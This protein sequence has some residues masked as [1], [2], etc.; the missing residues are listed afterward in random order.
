V[1]TLSRPR[2]R[3]GP[4]PSGRI[5][6]ALVFLAALA[7]LAVARAHS[8]SGDRLTSKR[9][10]AAA[11]A[12]P[13][14]GAFLK[15]TGY[16]RYR[17]TPL[18]DRLVRVSFFDGSRIVLEA[19]VAPDG[20]VPH[21]LFYRPGYIRSG[22]KTAQRPWVLVL[23]CAVFALA[24]A[25]VPLRSLRNLDVLALVSFTVPAA[26]LNARL[27]EASVYTSYP[28]LA[29][30]AGRCL[31][32][33]LRPGGAESG[34]RPG[35]LYERVTRSWSERARGRML[36]IG[37]ISASVGLL[38]VSIPG[39]LVGDVAYA[40]MAGATDL[41]HG[42]LP[43]GHLPTG[44]LVHG[45]TYPLL[46]YV[47]Y[48]PAAIFAPVKDGFDNMDGALYVATGFALAAAAALYVAG[49]RSGGGSTGPRLALA[50]LCFPPVVIAA[51][52]GSND[53]AAASCVAFAAALITYP[54]G[55]AFAMTLASWIKIGPFLILPAW[56]LR[57]RG[58]GLAR[59]LAAV[60]AVTAAVAT[61]VIALGGTGG[62]E[63]MLNAVSFQAGR[64]SLLSIWTLTG[65]QTLQLGFQAA[66]VTVA[67]LGAI[68]ARRDHLFA[69][70]P[71]R[72]AALAAAVLLGA[73]I[74]ANYWTYAYLPWVF[75]LIALA[76][77]SDARRR[78]TVRARP[79]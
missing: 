79:A 74:G 37:L 60:A 71:R 46:A 13:E 14:A 56:V 78:R 44:D 61:W 45:D 22:S 15:E 2:A 7:L 38:L 26:L 77:L 54:A 33:A 67:V 8:S 72:V 42:V 24:T 69:R 16:T 53:L 51:S 18:D 76:L 39:G 75:P 31:H 63:D 49:R 57:S 6:V 28:L 1:T 35:G 9:A 34:A 23:L 5:A 11:V 43:Y 10:V 48:I 40:S 68:R 20:S 50:W 59:A 25:T 17:V 47:A 32:V 64:G 58:P 4:L 29:Y 73:Q 52:S 70:D 41:L 19:A 12:D 27:L 66:L 36:G 30:L 3:I 65:A 55:S 62:L 21:R